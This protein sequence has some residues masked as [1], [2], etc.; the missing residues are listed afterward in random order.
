MTRSS[1]DERSPHPLDIALGLRVRLR[2]NELGLSQAKLAKATGIT[3]QQVQKYET[4]TNRISF[5]RL[6]EISQ[7]LD[8]GVRD[9]IADLGKAKSTA[10]ISKAMA[11]LA[12]PGAAAL[13][14]TYQRIAPQRRR[15]VVK[16]AR[17][18]ASDK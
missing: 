10:A 16:L 7:A 9:L 18:L 15:A 14:E 3:F 1:S 13:L 6:V 17:Q 11:A 2:R 4:G 5:S 8:C 12:M